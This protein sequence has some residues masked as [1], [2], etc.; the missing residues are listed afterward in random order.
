MQ[1]QQGADVHPGGEAGHG[2]WRAAGPFGVVGQQPGEAVAV[3][4]VAAVAAFDVGEDL[5]Q[6]VGAY[7]DPAAVGGVLVVGEDL[8]PGPGVQP[9]RERQAV[10]AVGQGPAAVGPGRVQAHGAVGLGPR[11]AG[12]WAAR[13]GVGP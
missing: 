7:L 6:R 3:L 5:P 13:S 1:Q 12:E 2:Q 11:W 4:L 9:A 8:D 10:D